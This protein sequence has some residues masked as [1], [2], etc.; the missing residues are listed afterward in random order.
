MRSSLVGKVQRSS[1]KYRRDS[2]KWRGQLQ[3][4]TGLPWAGGGASGSV[5]QHSPPLFRYNCTEAG[6]ESTGQPFPHG[7]IGTRFV[8]ATRDG[9]SACVPS[10]TIIMPD[11][12]DAR[13]YGDC[14]VAWRFGTSCDKPPP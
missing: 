8:L 12:E 11:D 4:R 10:H 2:L 3:R 1:P 6:Q 5:F 14:E 13:F 9:G 7:G